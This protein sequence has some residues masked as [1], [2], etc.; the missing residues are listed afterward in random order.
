[1]ELI[2]KSTKSPDERMTTPG[3]RLDAAVLNLD[4]QFVAVGTLLPGWRWSEDVRPTVGGTSCQF[5]HTGYLLEG[6]L[7]IEMDDGTAVDVHAGEAYQIPPGHDGW[8]VG[9]QA[10]RAV[11]WGNRVEEYAEKA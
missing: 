1:M 2:I 9:D 10:V 11:D 7:H 8:V 4:D 3:G 6:T 5:V